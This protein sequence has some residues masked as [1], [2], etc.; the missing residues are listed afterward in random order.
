MIDL[1][2]LVSVSSFLGQ[3]VRY[4]A[5]KSYTRTGSE[6]SDAIKLDVLWVNRYRNGLSTQFPRSPR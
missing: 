1:L 3:S 6:A 2:Y 4:W 5:S